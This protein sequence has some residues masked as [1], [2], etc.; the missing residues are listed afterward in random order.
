MGKLRRFVIISALALCLPLTQVRVLARPGESSAG[1][2]ITLQ[3]E[4]LLDG[5]NIVNILDDFDTFWEAAKGKNIRRQRALWARM[6]ESKYPDYFNKA[7]YRN[8]DP[9]TRRAML[10]AFLQAIPSHVD[11][12]R[13][14]NKRAAQ[15]IMDG[16]ADF[17]AHFPDYQQQRDVYIGLSLFTFDAAV[18]PV[19]NDLGVLDTL[20][21]GA[22]V[23]S[24][25]SPAQLKITV[26][27]ELFHLYNFKYLFGGVYHLAPGGLIFQQEV[28]NRLIP[29]YVP[30]MVEGMAV[31]ASEQ[32]YPGQPPSMY[33]H[34]SADELA[35]QQDDISQNALFFLNMM[36]VGALPN[37]YEPWFSGELE[38][39]PHRGGYFLGYEVIKRALALTTLEKIARMTPAQLGLQAESQLS[40]MVTDKL[41]VMSAQ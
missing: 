18:R 24:S 5:R 20:C 29:A 11:A 21:L 23:L 6:V 10:D 38:G 26:V 36:K 30:L 9:D 41:F 27:H 13:D 25:Y 17:E 7:V 39:I 34:L 35:E 4:A 32:I 22:D 12:I 15:S 37:Q 40:A 1:A 31:A 33:L 2:T 8:A 14:F 28:M 16:V 3:S 19:S